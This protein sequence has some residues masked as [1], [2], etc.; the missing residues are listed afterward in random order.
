MLSTRSA[1]RREE[2]RRF[3]V[4][5][6][7]SAGQLLAGGTPSDGVQIWNIQNPTAP[8]D[9]VDSPGTLNDVHFCRNNENVALA[10]SNLTLVPFAREGEP[11]VVRGDQA[12]YGSVRFSSEAR[13]L[14]TINGKGAVRPV[15]CC[16]SIWAEVDCDPEE[17][18][19]LWAGHWPGVWDL[20]SMTMLGRLAKRRESMAFG[21]IAIDQST[22]DTPEIESS[23]RS[24]TR[25]L[26]LAKAD[27]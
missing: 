23:I 27:G 11:V 20:R 19:A 25:S 6:L 12:N 17:S 10:N 15:H 14:L 5:A 21:P 8:H 26:C 7:S 22:Q 2:P 4:L 1:P 24:R 3:H 13:L 9:L 18:R 16:S